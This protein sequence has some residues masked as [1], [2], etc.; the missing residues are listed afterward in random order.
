MVVAYFVTKINWND[1][2]M[3]L[4]TPLLLLLMFFSMT[5][6]AQDGK[7]PNGKESV[8]FDVTMHCES[9]KKKM[10]KNIPY[11]K[12]VT[13]LKVNMNDKTVWIEYKKDKTNVEK[14][15]KAIEKLGYEA[16]IHAD[17]DTVQNAI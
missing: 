17:A 7:K 5:A 15:Q 9:C 16:T 1:M 12:G 3:K 8:L 2:K 6:V 10:E 14:L 13:D 11:E 4:F